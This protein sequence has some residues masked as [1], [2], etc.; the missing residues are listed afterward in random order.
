MK[1]EKVE[2]HI[3]AILG[4][5]ETLESYFLAQELHRRWFLLLGPL[6]ALTLRSYYIAVTSEGVHFHRV[7]LRDRI[8]MSDFFSYSEITAVNVKGGMLQKPLRFSFSNGRTLKVKAQ[9]KGVASVPKL[10]A[11]TETI[12]LSRVEGGE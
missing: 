3:T 11:E 4:E 2:Q 6:A 5:N 1:K 12:L 8:A 7:D 10:T 9:V